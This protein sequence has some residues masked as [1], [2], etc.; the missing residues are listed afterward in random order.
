MRIGS[1]LFIAT[2]VFAVTLLPVHALSSVEVSSPTQNSVYNVGSSVAITGQITI[3]EDAAGATVSFSAVSKRL[4][5]TVAIK[6]AIYSF[7]ANTPVSFTQINKGTL[8]WAIPFETVQSD[9]WKIYVTVDRPI[10]KYVEFSSVSFTISKSLSLSVS[11]NTRLLN[12]GETIEASGTA[13]DAN[14]N[15][16]TGTASVAMDHGVLGDVSSES[17]QIN[18]GFLTFSY[19]LKPSDP[20]GDYSLTFKVTDESGNSALKLIQ[21]IVVSDKLEVNCTLPAQ[22]LK[23]GSE[24]DLIGTLRNIHGKPVKD[25]PVIS[26]LTFPNKPVSINFN[27]SKSDA[28]GNFAVHISLP[29]L[30][31]PGTYA[32]DAIAEDGNG[33]SGACYKTFPLGTTQNVLVGLNLNSSWFYQSTDAGIELNIKN[34]GNT[35]LVGTATVFVDEKQADSFDFAVRKGEDASLGRTWHVSSPVGEHKITILLTSPD[36]KILTQ[37]VPQSFNVYAHPPQQKAFVLSVKTAFAIAVIV[38]MLCYILVRRN[39]IKSHLWHWQL[40]REYGV[41]GRRPLPKFKKKEQGEE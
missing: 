7:A 26:Y 8:S 37:T 29:Q 1:I 20:P 17:A 12:L 15:P 19:K 14:G 41:G 11:S 28:N 18:N 25:V 22:Q 27:N 40:R 38:V 33:N 32:L 13:L 6:S 2:L 30:A 34:G 10:T 31:G 35:D 36:A 23:P 9:D 21:G 5:K 4:N 24:F 3:D 16:I 39:E